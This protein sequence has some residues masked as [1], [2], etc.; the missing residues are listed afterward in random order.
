[1]P[2]SKPRLALIGYGEAGRAFARGWRAAGVTGDIR[3]FDIDPARSLSASRAAALEGAQAVFCLVT[4]DRA[5]EAF[6]QIAPHLP[7][8]P[9][10]GPPSGPS[11]G[12]L[13]FDGN[14]CAP[15]TKRENA[16]VV[17]GAGGRY[18]DMAIMAP[19]HPRLHETPVLLAGPHAEAGRGMLAR[20][21]MR[22]RV[23][24][25][26]VGQASAIK[27]IRSVMVKG[28]EALFAECVLA[29][30]RAGVE[31]VVLDSLQDSFPEFDWAARAAY[32][33]ERMMVHGTRRAA[34]M[35]EVARTV[36]ELGLSGAMSEASAHWQALV[37]GLGLEAGVDDVRARS[38]AILAVL[39]GAGPGGAGR[40]GEAC[41]GEAC[42][43]EACV[44]EACVGGGAAPV[45]GATPPAYL[46]KEEE[47]GEDR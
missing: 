43:G 4:A 40:V 3:A 21:G 23:A 15:A 6:E 25:D 16:L 5:T 24:G 39:G 7:P 34:E 27:M 20:L 9:P 47:E 8:D 19:V 36:R 31:D 37:G 17:E 22:S 44:G 38:D 13:V 30:R 10:S 26:E 12:V 45:A 42:V 46:G 14:S 1:M 28:M 29:G 2:D 18:V 41:V 11:G 33:L 32:S 35:R